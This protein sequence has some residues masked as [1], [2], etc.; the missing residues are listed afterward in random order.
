MARAARREL[1]SARPAAALARARRRSRS[2]PADLDGER[3]AARRLAGVAPALERRRAPDDRARGRSSQEAPGLAGVTVSWGAG[4][5]C[6]SIAGAAGCS[7]ASEAGAARSGSG[8][9]SVPRAARAGSSAKA[10]G[11]RCCATRRTGRR[12]T[13]PGS[14]S[15][16][17]R[18]RG[19]RRPGPLVLGDAAER[20]VGRRRRRRS[21][22]ADTPRPAYE[23][24]ARAVR[25]AR[26]RPPRYDA[27]VQRRAVRATGRR[28]VQLP[29]GQAVA[30]RSAGGHAAPGGA[31][32]PRRARSSEAA[33]AYERELEKA[34]E[35]EFSLVLLGLGPDGHLASMFPDQA[36]LSERSRLVVGVEEAGLEP[37]VPRVTLT[38]P[39]ARER[40]AASCSWS[41]GRRR[42]TRSRAAFGPDADSDPHVPGVDAASRSQK[43]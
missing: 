6:R 43:S 27:V 40:R 26:A 39:G 42:P 21:P 14:W 28:A 22:A 34:G 35:P 29:A 16:E 9:C 23:E 30:A 12:S 18:D 17:P 5:R 11:R 32:D 25:A 37:F 2:P 15:R 1:R 33:E 31:P 38:L 36:S 24:L 41:P 10:S 19:R 7:R 20:D 3:G 13:R 8:G 4:A